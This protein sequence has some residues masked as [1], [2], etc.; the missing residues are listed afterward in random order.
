MER[1][2]EH[3]NFGLGSRYLANAGMNALKEAQYSFKTVAT[4]T[5]HFRQFAN[6]VRSEHG[7]KDLK[8]I[9]K[10]HVIAFAEQL[11][12]RLNKNEISASTAQNR[13]SAVNVVLSIARQD[14]LCHVNPVRD[15]GLAKRTFVATESKSIPAF[16]HDQTKVQ[17][18]ERLA[19]QLDLQRELGLRFKESVL[20]NAQQSLKQARNGIIRIENGTKG[21]R[22]REIPITNARQLAVLQSAAALQGNHY[23][24][25]PETKSLREYTQDCYRSLQQTSLKGFHGERHTYAN[26]RYEKLVGVKSP[27]EA[28]IRHGLPH[29]KHIA[30]QLG[31]EKESALKL[32]IEARM[33]ISNELGHSRIAITNNYL[34]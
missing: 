21:G 17:V 25:V 33:T 10:S 9:E 3:R 5:S 27:V 1:K 16:L 7:I 13:L 29:I 32:D 30:S 11:K 23:S 8:Q 24:L 2:L 26:Q 34:G 28:R 6:F 18:P 14:T 20:L 31:I 22:I 19:V 15:A 12:D 4:N